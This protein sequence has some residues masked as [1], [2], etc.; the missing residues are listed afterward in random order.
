MLRYAEEMCK[1]HVEVP[2]EV[3][4]AL[5]RHFSEDQIVEL[6]ASIALENFRARFNRAL[7][8]QSDALCMLPMYKPVVKPAAA[9]QG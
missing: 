8:I 7:E 6:T 1:E 2:D 5:A 9:Q 4:R 3:Y